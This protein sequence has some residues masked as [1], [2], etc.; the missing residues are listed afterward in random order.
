MNE[1]E[2]QASVGTTRGEAIPANGPTPPGV[3]TPQ[4]MKVMKQWARDLAI[5]M[6]IAWFIIAFLYQQVRVDGTSMMPGLMD[7]DRLIINKFLYRFAGIKH[8]DVVVFLYPGDHKLSYIKR[9]IGMPGDDVR[10]DHGRIYVN[11][12]ELV[13]PYIAEQYRD[14]RSVPDVVVPAGEV[15]VLGDHRN[16]ASDS[17]NFGAFSQKLIYG[18]ATYI[19][20]PVRDSGT[21]K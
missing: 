20:W 7:G 19:Y 3:A 5:S 17:R 8:G 2:V 4:Q 9:V 13:E 21:V 14:D 1:T 15:Y 16:I 10:E 18:K 12:T 11:G 6:F